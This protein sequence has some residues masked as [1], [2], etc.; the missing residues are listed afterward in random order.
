MDV[1]I[2]EDEKLASNKLIMLLK[3][4][5]A[6][7]QTKKVLT[8]VQESIKW[9]SSNQCDL[10]FLDINLSDD[11]S[12]NIFNEVKID[13]PII[14]TTAY[15]EYAIRAFEQN[16]LA[17][18]LKPIDKE[19]LEKSLQKFHSLNRRAES[20]WNQKL[21]G[22]ISDFST[23]NGKTKDRFSVSYGGKMRSI[24]TKDVALFYV[25]DRIVYLVT[26][27]GTRYVMDKTLEK[28]E[29]ELNQEFYRVNRQYLIHIDAIDEVIPF[30]SRKLKINTKV[31]T[32]E[33][34]LVPTD[35]ITSFK[36]W[37][38]AD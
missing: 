6:G 25:K 33:S 32:D 21:E 16:S 34:I 14:F 22:L 36:Q 26:H 8:S 27:S 5:D 11:L 17:Y 1:V 35:K 20:L 3:S 7:I 15:D 9:L 30:S 12:F 18:L 23:Q 38:D 13:T 28:I 29:E 10:I 19:E 2:I 31:A 4:I 37:F 24:A